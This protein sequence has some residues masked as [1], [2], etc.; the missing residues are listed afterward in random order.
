MRRAALHILASARKAFRKAAR[1]SA[2]TLAV[3]AAA[4]T[5]LPSCSVHEWPDTGTLAQLRLDFRFATDLPPY[6]EIKYGTK[7]DI[8]PEDYDVRYKVKFYPELTG[9]GYDTADA[10]AYALTLTK[11]DVSELNW[12]A[13]AAL[14]EGKWQVRCWVD[15]VAQGSDKDLFYDT[16]DFS[17]ITIPEEHT[18]NNDYKDAFLG[19]AEVELHRVGSREEPVS[20]TL[21]MERPLAKFQ[22]IATDLEQ[23]VTKVLREKATRRS[24]TDSDR[25]ESPLEQS[26]RPEDYYIRFYYTSYMPCVFNI[27]TNKP[28]DSRTG[29]QF[30][31]EFT[32][33][34]ENEVLM[35][36][37]YVLV[38]GAE[39]SVLV[40]VAL[41]DRETRE[42]L[43]LTP[44]VSV[45][46]VRSKVTTVR[47]DFLTLGA[48]GGLGINPDF[49]D[50]YNVYL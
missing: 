8:S 5:L 38:N 30:E 4:L 46:L 41:Y 40:Q 16:E 3:L 47:G 26:F 35:G 6:L 28:V 31:S 44:A 7:T 15:Y 12:T 14:P 23:L 42:L 11:D 34:S 13:C 45:P 17:S 10:A 33:I 48:G 50:E 32:P 36:Y 25:P 1:I 21:D 9:G 49:D 18:A 20:V 29:V 27:Y 39:S 24:R 19:S 37:D 2:G 43:S 22:F